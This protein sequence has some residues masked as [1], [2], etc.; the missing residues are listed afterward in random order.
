MI[1]ATIL[2]GML[3]YKQDMNVEETFA[4]WIIQAKT[5]RR[6]DSQA[7]D[8]RQQF[9]TRIQINGKI[10]ILARKP[11]H[12]FSGRQSG[13]PAGGLIQWHLAYEVIGQV[14]T[15]ERPGF[16]DNKHDLRPQASD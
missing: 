6:I 8:R 16:T 5:Y 15:F 1:S 12:Y 7:E 13:P 14:A 10:E 4:V 3:I 11:V 2:H 9:R